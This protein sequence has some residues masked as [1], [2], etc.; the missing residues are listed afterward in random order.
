MDG[1]SKG[2][3]YLTKQQARNRF[4]ALIWSLV[5]KLA[6]KAMVTGGLHL[7]LTRLM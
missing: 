1:C 2:V 7:G 5:E 4:E 3:M 6:R